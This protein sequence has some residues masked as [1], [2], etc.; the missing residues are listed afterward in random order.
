MRLIIGITVLVVLCILFAGCT[1]MPKGSGTT[2][3]IPAKP[4]TVTPIPTPAFPPKYGMGDVVL[5]SS[6]DNIGKVVISSTASQYTVRPVFIDEYGTVYYFETN[7][8]QVLSRQDIENSYSFKFGNLDNPYNLQIYKPSHKPKFS[9][10]VILTEDKFPLQGVLI[11]KYDYVNDIYV[12]TT[13][14]NQGGIWVYD[15]SAKM[16]QERSKI[17]V[18][19][20]KITTTVKV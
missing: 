18:K 15:T 2:P 16:R 14:Y 11:L 8:N 19:Y 6:F 7:G 12:Y 17:E 4:G 20:K 10:G 3:L 9:N 1:Q 5:K 13:A